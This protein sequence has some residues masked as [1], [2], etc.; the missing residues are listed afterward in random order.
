MAK[1]TKQV[2]K[3]GRPPQSELWFESKRDDGVLRYAADWAKALKA[4]GGYDYTT[5]KLTPMKK[6]KG[7]EKFD[8]H[9]WFAAD[10]ICAAYEEG[11]IGGANWVAQCFATKGDLEAF[12]YALSQQDMEWMHERH[13][14]AFYALGVNDDYIAS[15]LTVADYLDE[16]VLPE[17]Q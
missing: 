4:H 5:G 15:Y 11:L 7:L 10:S 1:T 12:S 2:Q 3:P 13:H 17:M 14:A 16:H 8:F 6:V 9:C